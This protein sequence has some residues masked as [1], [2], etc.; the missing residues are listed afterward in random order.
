M[1]R[2]IFY[3]EKD[4]YFKSKKNELYKKFCMSNVDCLSEN[5]LV[6]DIIKEYCKHNYIEYYPVEDFKK[7]WWFPNVCYEKILSFTQLPIV[8]RCL[9]LKKL[10]RVILV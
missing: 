7:C 2:M 8:K 10:L 4:Q 6:L 5:I 1:K 3:E 9:C